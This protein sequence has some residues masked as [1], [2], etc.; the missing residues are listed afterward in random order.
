PVYLPGKTVLDPVERLQMDAYR[1]I[2][3]YLRGNRSF[4]EAGAKALAALSPIK[5]AV[6]VTSKNWRAFSL[7]LEQCIE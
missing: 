1:R 4:T 6:E 2:Y 3:D 7:S 5:N